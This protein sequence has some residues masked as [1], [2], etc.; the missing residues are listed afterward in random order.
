VIRS[1]PPPGKDVPQGTQIVVYV[2]S[3]PAVPV[4]NM[5]G[6]VQAVAEHEILKL[7][8]VP[9]VVFLPGGGARPHVVRMDPPAGSKLGSGEKVTLF[10]G[11]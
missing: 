3:G 5:V 1:D 4:P 6:E 2:S 10:V 9:D 11:N 8:L 7:G